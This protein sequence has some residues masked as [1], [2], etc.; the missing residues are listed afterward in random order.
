VPWSRRVLELGI[1]IGPVELACQWVPATISTFLQRVGLE[2]LPHGVPRHYLPDN[3]D[4]LVEC[5]AL[6]RP[7][8]KA[9]STPS[10]PL[11]LS[12]YWPS[13]HRRVAAAESGKRTSSTTGTPGRPY[14]HL[15]RETS[16]P[17][18]LAARASPP[19]G[20]R[21]P[22]S[23]APGQLGPEGRRVLAGRTDQRG[24]IP[25]SRLPGR[26]RAEESVVAPSTRTSPSSR[27]R[28]VFLSHPFLAHPP[29]H[30]GEVRSP[31]RRPGP[32][33]LLVRGP[34]RTATLEEV[35]R[36]KTGVESHLKQEAPRRRLLRREPAPR[37]DPGAADQ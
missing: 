5:A 6:L 16:T 17:V 10:C 19:Q 34:A 28:D 23:T 13:S 31:T 26:G 25:K 7:C 4:E 20:P 22:T 24:A 15:S 33:S 12:T 2:P 29:C 35:S 11:A 32:P 21:M 1:D 18:E 14:E 3:T 8:A 36:S 30:P 9:V 37:D 27:C